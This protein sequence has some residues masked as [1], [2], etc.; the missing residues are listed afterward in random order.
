[1]N[2]LMLLK[3][4]ANS[5]LA[6]SGGFVCALSTTFL[7]HGTALLRL[8]FCSGSVDGWVEGLLVLSLCGSHWQ[9]QFCIW[10]ALRRIPSISSFPL[11]NLQLFLFLFLLQ[12]LG[13]CWSRYHK[14]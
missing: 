2:W 14:C 3:I 10:L 11:P 9:P 1:M 13:L 8:W 5:Y 12:F 6:P 4:T 7:R